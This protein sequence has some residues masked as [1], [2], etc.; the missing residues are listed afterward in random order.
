MPWL[1]KSVI[2]ARCIPDV[3]VPRSNLILCQERGAVN[4]SE[5]PGT[6]SERSIAK[7][8]ACPWRCP[9]MMLSSR[10]SV[11]VQG[12]LALSCSIDKGQPSIRTYI[13]RDN[14]AISNTHEFDNGKC[15]APGASS[16]PSTQSLRPHSN[17][18][19]RGLPCR[20]DPGLVL[21]VRLLGRFREELG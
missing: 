8:K 4:I 18:R 7:G 17:R 11:S 5:I 13:N 6:L 19:V 10:F 15:L 2:S 14:I 21:I 16:E 9:C 3:P 12:E 20:G 1:F